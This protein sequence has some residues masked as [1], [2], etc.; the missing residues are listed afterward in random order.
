MSPN[1][2]QI[3]NRD[4]IWDYPKQVYTDKQT[5]ETFEKTLFTQSLPITIPSAGG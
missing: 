3:V 4:K 5:L 2:K 1:L